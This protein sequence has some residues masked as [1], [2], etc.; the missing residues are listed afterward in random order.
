VF[1]E[2]NEHGI[3]ARMHFTCCSRCGHAEIGAEAAEGSRG[4]TFFHMQDTERVAGGG[5]LWLNFGGFTQ[6]TETVGSEVTEA[7]TAAGF[8][9]IW[10]N[11]PNTSIRIT[12]LN[13]RKRLET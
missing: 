2:L 1:D 8:S 7:L 5:D 11:S 13:W 3:T 6:A 10:N 9:V 12:D 4:Y